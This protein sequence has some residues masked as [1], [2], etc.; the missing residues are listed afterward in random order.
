MIY[1]ELYSR[2]PGP[3]YAQ[4]VHG[5]GQGHGQ[6]PGHGPGQGHG[7]MPGYGPGQGHGQV[8]GHGPGYGPGHG[9]G[10]GPGQGHGPGYGP[11]HGFPGPGGYWSGGYYILDG[12]RW[13]FVPGVGWVVV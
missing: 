12:R 8:P 6:V 7:Q 13:Y 4:P 1:D 3:G 11:G 5:P 2:Y 9:P 10:Y